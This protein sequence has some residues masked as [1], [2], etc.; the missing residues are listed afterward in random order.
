MIKKKKTNLLD[1]FFKS[2]DPG[3]IEDNSLRKDMLQDTPYDNESMTKIDQ[4]IKSRFIGSKRNWVQRLKSG[5]AKTSASLS[6]GISQVFAKRQLDSESF[7][8]LEDLLIQADLGI[9]TTAR[10]VDHLSS[11]RYDKTISPKEVLEVLANEI[12]IILEP[13]AQKLDIVASRKPHVILVVGVNGTGKTTTIGKLAAKYCSEGRKVLLVA[14][15]TFR[16]A[17][18]E[19]LQIWGDRVGCEVA[20]RNA[21][22]DSAS[23][24]F[25]ALTKAKEQNIDI[26]MMDTAGRLH[27]KKELMDELGKIIRVIRKVDATAPHDVLL[28]VDA[29]TG[30]NA[31]R[32]V[33]AFRD[34]AGITGLIMTKLDGTASGGIIVAIAAQYGIPVHAI[35]VGEGVED[36]APFDA[37]EFALAIAQPKNIELDNSDTH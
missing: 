17:A 29:T 22:A 15:D 10:I 28:V 31:L 27:N 36:L 25:D 8:D 33:E 11:N 37:K 26:L 1:R 18:I 24:G 2:N 6:E 5:L 9:E 21:G 4:T 12:E 20:H 19:Q 23:L 30:Q 14:G 16:A 13:V 3:S 32:Q 35:G 34:R 7:E